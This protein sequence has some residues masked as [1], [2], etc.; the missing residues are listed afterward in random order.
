MAAN[1]QSSIDQLALDEFGSTLRGELVRPG[2][3]SYDERRRVWNASIDRYPVL[4]ARCAGVA[5]VIE[6][7]RFA[8]THQLLVAVRAGGHSYPGYGVCDD[9]MVIDLS[10]MKG[11]RVDPEARTVRAQ[12]GVLLGELDRET[13][14]FGC[15][16]PAGFISHTGMAGL[17]LGGGIGFTMR[18]L[19]LTIDNL[20]SVDLI[21]AEGEFVKASAQENADLFWGLRGGGGNFGIATEFEFRLNPLGPVIYAGP[22]FWPLDEAPRVLRFYRDWIADCP[23]ELTTLVTERRAPATLAG[24]PPD[25]VGQHMIA[26]TSIYAGSIDEGEKVVRP[27]K[28]FDSPALDRCAPMPYLT[29]QQLFNASFPRGGGTTSVRVTSPSSM[30]TSSTSWCSTASRSSLRSRPWGSGKAVVRS[31]ASARARLLSTAGAP[32]TRSTSAET[33]RAPRASKKSEHGSIDSGRPFSRITP[34]CT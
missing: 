16:V 22:I 26:I 15:A 18:K 12:A 13:Q 19:G 20:L 28:G 34:A 21:T 1:E 10:L 33:P 4:I 11:I 31:L 29:L 25:L 8:R 7:V 5:D 6:A 30:T 23:D 17:T 14:A 2:D 9:G 24:L 32:A 3:G 27:L